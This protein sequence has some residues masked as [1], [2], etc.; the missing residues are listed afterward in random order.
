MQIIINTAD[1]YVSVHG[2][3][4]Y[5]PD[6]DWT[7]FNGGSSLFDDIDFVHFD[8]ELGSG[9]VSYKTVTT[10]QLARENITP[11]DWKITAKDFEENFAWVLPLYEAR[12]AELA[13]ER[14]ARDQ[15]L[16]DRR[17][18][19]ALQPRHS[20]SGEAGASADPGAMNDV[21]AKLAAIEDENAALKARVAS[22]D[23]AFDNIANVKPPS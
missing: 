20:G 5:L 19:E 6:L 11:P 21:L 18:S 13:S 7:K 8:P 22:H 4:V 23:A 10:E 16:E 17:A 9:A 3:V 1:K 12:D 2:Q 15:A 14:A